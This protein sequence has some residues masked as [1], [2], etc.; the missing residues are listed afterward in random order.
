MVDN[1]WATLRQR[2]RSVQELD[3]LGLQPFGPERRVLKPNG[4]S[5][6]EAVYGTDEGYKL[7]LAT[8][9]DGIQSV[10]RG[11][12]EFFNRKLRD[13]L[14]N[15]ELSYIQKQAQNRHRAMAEATRSGRTQR[16]DNDLRHRKR[17]CP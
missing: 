13:E 11:Y 12:C 5:Q 4:L 8:T 7:A 16:L 2:W 1:L 17:S 14:L 10:V 15:G 3:S 6:L 9:L